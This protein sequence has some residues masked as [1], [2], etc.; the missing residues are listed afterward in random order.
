MKWLLRLY[1]AAWRR[2][3]GAEFL[4]LLEARPLTARVLLDVVLGALDARAR[5]QLGSVPAEAPAT[6]RARPSRNSFGAFTPRSRAALHVAQAEATLLRH[7]FIGTE[8]LLLGLLH[9]PDSVA[10]HVLRSLDVDAAALRLEIGRRLSAAPRS[11]RPARGLTSRTKQAITLSVD[12]ATRLRHPYVGTEHLLVG[13]LLEGEGTAAVVLREVAGLDV[14]EARRRVVQAL[15][16]GPEL[17][18]R[19]PS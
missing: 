15:I 11:N 5:P 8:H 10:S 2:R 17:P 18:Q 12:E 9:D 14:D 13:L 6:A 4:A 7:D 19:P 16:H 3:Y 1:P